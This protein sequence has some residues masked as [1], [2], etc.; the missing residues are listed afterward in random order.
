MYGILL[1]PGHIP[2][3]ARILQAKPGHTN[4]NQNQTLAKKSRNGDTLG[5]VELIVRPEQANQGEQREQDDQGE[6]SII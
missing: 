6:V 3:T 5:P 1:D 4:W 2:I